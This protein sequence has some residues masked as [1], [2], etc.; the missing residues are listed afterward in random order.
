MLFPDAV[1]DQGTISKPCTN[2]ELNAIENVNQK[3]EEFAKRDASDDSFAIYAF[4]AIPSSTPCYCES[5]ERLSHRHTHRL[6]QSD[7]IECSLQSRS[8]TFALRLLSGSAL[9]V[10]PMSLTAANISFPPD[11]IAGVEKQPVSLLLQIAGWPFTIPDFSPLSISCAPTGA[12]GATLSAVPHKIV[13][14][15]ETRWLINV[16]FPGSGKFLTRIVWAGDTVE[17]G[18]D[19]ETTIEA[20]M[21]HGVAPLLT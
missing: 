4:P 9:C 12:A 18:R 14:T 20:G 1:S 8:L 10:T 15:E 13:S 16:E 17:G 5:P 2:T 6:A 3:Q 19:I 21:C 7:G 11:R